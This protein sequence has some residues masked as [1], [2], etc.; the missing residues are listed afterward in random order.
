MYVFK[1]SEFDELMQEPHNCTY[2]TNGK[3]WEK[4]IFFSEVSTNM[5]IYL[6]WSKFLSY[7][8]KFKWREEVFLQQFLGGFVVL[9]CLVLCVCV[10]VHACLCL[11]RGILF[12]QL[13][14]CQLLSYKMT[15]A[16]TDPWEEFWNAVFCTVIGQ[17][18]YGTWY[19]SKA[20]TN[21][22]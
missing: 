1:Y 9:V 18:P 22:V 17:L 12:L 16:Y 6:S 2:K 21:H 11:H 19:S 10:C 4:C 3:F 8:T 5:C 14:H 7:V 13:L 15:N 20:S